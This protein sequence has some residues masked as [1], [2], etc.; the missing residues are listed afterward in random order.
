MILW[1]TLAILAISIIWCCLRKTD[2]SGSADKVFVLAI[3]IG[4][5]FVVMLIILML[6]HVDFHTLVVERNAVQTTL[7][8][9]RESIDMHMLEKVGAIQQVF[10]INKQIAVAKY[11]SSSIW[12]GIFWPDGVAD[13]NYIK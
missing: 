4:F 10:E 13:L 11:W 3:I 9:Y 1:I 7:D 12:V 6:V 8:E 2:Q 5:V